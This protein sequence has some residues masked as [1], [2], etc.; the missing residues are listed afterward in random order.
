[1][2]AYSASRSMAIGSTIVAALIVVAHRGNLARL[3]SGAERALGT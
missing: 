2:W 3:L 1:M